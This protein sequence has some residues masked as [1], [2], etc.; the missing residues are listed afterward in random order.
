VIFTTSPP[1]PATYYDPP[2]G[3][4][5]IDSIT[6]TLAG[7]VRLEVPADKWGDLKV[8]DDLV[9]RAFAQEREEEAA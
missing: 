2:E 3:G 1:T 6:V 8:Y 5:Q 7:G 9:E 4:I